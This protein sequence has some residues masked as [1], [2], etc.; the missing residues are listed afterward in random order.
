[1]PGMRPAVPALMNSNTVSWVTAKSGSRNA[2]LVKSR[3]KANI[4]LPVQKTQV[5]LCLFGFSNAPKTNDELYRRG[6]CSH[7]GDECLVI[8]LG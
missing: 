5:E 2:F 4:R 6:G 1:M 7:A 3:N 8:A